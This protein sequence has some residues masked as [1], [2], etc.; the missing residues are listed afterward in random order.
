MKA[1]AWILMLLIG[2]ISL[3]GFCTTTDLV[4]NSEIEKDVC[5]EADAFTQSFVASVPIEL[6]TDNS[7]VM[8]RAKIPIEVTLNYNEH[9]CVYCEAIYTRNLKNNLV[10]TNYRKARDGLRIN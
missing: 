10:L 2:M 5:F 7:F 8:F 4:Q 9:Y 6:M 3:T 1:K